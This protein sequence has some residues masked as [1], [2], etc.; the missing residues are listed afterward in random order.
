VKSDDGPDAVS[1]ADK[2]FVAAQL[3][4]MIER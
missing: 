2:P 1:L 4:G 3:L